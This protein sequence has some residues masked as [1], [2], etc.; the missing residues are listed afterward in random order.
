ML[1]N[2]VYRAY[3]YA[4]DYPGLQGLDLTPGKP[5]ELY[6]T[7]W[8]AY[9]ELMVKTAVKVDGATEKTPKTVRIMV[10]P[11][12]IDDKGEGTTPFTRAFRDNTNITL[13]APSSPSSLDHNGVNLTFKGWEDGNGNLLGSNPTLALLM[14][15]DK[16]LTACYEVATHI[17]TTNSMPSGIEITETLADRNSEATGTTPFTREYA[18][19][20]AV[21]L[22]A[23]ESYKSE[24]G[25]KM[26]RNWAV[27]GVDAGQDLAV[28]VTID[29]NHT[30]QA[31]YTNPPLKFTMTLP[32][33]VSLIHRP[34]VVEKVSN[35]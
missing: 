26:F 14:D 30:V 24:D 16:T 32:K 33:G 23:P 35:S 20:T 3:W 7:P 18:A 10:R 8:N 13:T 2:S 21:T 12:D 17:L 4:P 28:T 25:V 27:D 19:G 5:I 31:N 6:R 29:A 22:T 11:T 1:N 34:F 15:A 9:P